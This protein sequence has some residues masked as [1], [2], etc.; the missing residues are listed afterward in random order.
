M[1]QQITIRRSNKPSASLWWQPFF[2]AQRQAHRS[3]RESFSHFAPPS[4]F[5]PSI[6]DIEGDLFSYVQDNIHNVFSELFNNRQV[7]TQLSAGQNGPYIDIIENGNK[8]KV[9]AEVPGIEA[10]D[11]DVTVENNTIT[12]Q[13]E[14]QE[15]VKEEGDEYVRQECRCSSF[16]RTIALPKEANLEKASF[17]FDKNVLN[18][19]IPKKDAEKSR[20]VEINA[21]KEEHTYNEGDKNSVKIQGESS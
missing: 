14:K 9:R 20:K 16:R 3:F 7:L 15:E 5:G 11:L 6:L 2:A 8:F 17:T 13:G 12:I 4:F 18:I 10:K 19:E 1:S 21:N